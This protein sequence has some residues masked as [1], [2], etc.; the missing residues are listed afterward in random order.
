MR[1]FRAEVADS[2][3]R[4]VDIDTDLG[5]L[6]GQRNDPHVATRGLVSVSISHS[7]L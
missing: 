6:C 7:E 1:T 4:T 2:G 3:L 5:G